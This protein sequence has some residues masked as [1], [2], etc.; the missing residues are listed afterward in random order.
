M[1]IHYII[2]RRHL[3]V[4]HL[5]DDMQE[6]LQVAISAVNFIKANALHDSLFQ[7]LCEGV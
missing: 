4:K 2:H 1:A 3:A 5:I 7:Q 6:A